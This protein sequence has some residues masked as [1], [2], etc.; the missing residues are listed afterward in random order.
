MEIIIIGIGVVLL[1]GLLWAVATGKFTFNS[2]GSASLTAWHDFQPK[3]KQD[4]VEVI[5]EQKAG[6]RWEEQHSGE[7]ED[8]S[9]K[10]NEPQ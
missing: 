5:I 10:N 8:E 9:E 7:G 2:P 3:D 4:A 6:K 1:A